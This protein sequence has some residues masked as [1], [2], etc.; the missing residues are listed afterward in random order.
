MSDQTHLTNLSGDKKAWPVY[1]TLG[2]LPSSRRN[3]PTSM[4]VLLLALLPIAPKLSNSS[5]ADQHQRQINSD[6]LQDVFEL[7]IAPLQDP[8]HDSLPIDCAN[9]KVRMCFSILAAWIADHMENVALHGIKSNVCPRWEV[10]AVKL[11]TNMKLYPGRDYAIYHNYDYENWIGETD[12]ADI[13]PE[14]LGMRLGQNVFYRLNRISPSDLH[15]QDMLYTDYLG[16]FKHMMHWIQGFL[17]K[18]GRLEA[19]DEVWKALPPYPGCLV[20]KK[21]YREVRQL[22]GKDMRNLGRCVLSVLAVAL[23]Q[24]GSAQLIP[25][26]RALGSV[27]ALVDFNMMAQYRSHTAETLTYMEDYLDTVHKKQDIFLEFSVTKH[28]RAKIDEQ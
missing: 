28:I 2:N 20:P 8:A 13:R 17:K 23:C 12:H 1:I 18:Q 19:F 21:A 10:P 15:K 3:S 22:E 26:K 16:L 7:I 6:T 24:S 27:R 11:G 25:F 9:G 14:S 4:A 5:K